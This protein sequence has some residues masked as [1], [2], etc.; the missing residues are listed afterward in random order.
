MTLYA[1]RRCLDVVGRVAGSSSSLS[2]SWSATLVFQHRC[3]AARAT[4]QKLKEKPAA[5]AS[6]RT[7]EDELKAIEALHR[8]TETNEV[9]ISSAPLELLDLHVPT[10]KSSKEGATFLDHFRAVLQTQRNWLH[11]ARAMYRIA[12]ARSIPGVKVRSPWSWQL[13]ATQSTKPDAWLAPFRRA[14]L[15]VYKQVNEAVAARDEKTIKALTGGQQ[16]LEY[17]QLIRSQDPRYVNVWKFHGERT[18]CRV[19]SIR[20]LDAYYGVQAPR[21]GS[22]LAVQAVVRFDTLQSVETYS[23]K[24]GARVGESQPKPVVEYLVFQKRMWYDSPWVIRD[25]LY[26]GL[27]SRFNLPG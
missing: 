17:I 8:M 5:T 12:K 10:W 16:Q 18:P 25:R 24:T 15:E 26:E 6:E 21:M 20:A 23:K 7:T 1:S 4:A 2:R 3:Y 19:V 9:D 13:F 14:A 27:E 22:R 11:N